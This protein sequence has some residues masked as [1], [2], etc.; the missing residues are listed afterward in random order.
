MVSLGRRYVKHRRMLGYTLSNAGSLMAFANFIDRMAPGQ[1]VTTAR[2]LEWVTAVP[3]RKLTTQVGLLSTIRGFARYCAVLDPRTQIPGRHLLGPGY[4]RLRPHIYTPQQ[5]RLILRRAR[6]LTTHLGP[7]HPMTYETLIGLIACTGMRFGEARRLNLTDFDDDGALRIARFKASP[8]RIIPLHA[9]TVRA[10]QRYV[11]TRRRCFPFSDSLFVGVTGKPLRNSRVEAIFNRLVSGLSATGDRA[12]PRMSDFRHSFASGW[13]T[14]WSRQSNPIS[15]HLLL[16]A[17][18]L[19]HQNFS[20]TWWYVS[21][22]P[23]SLRTAAN[24]FLHFHEASTSLSPA[25]R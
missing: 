2:A 18:Y 11:R 13:I 21:S 19:G 16:L 14:E 4:T 15:H 6:T 8:Q 7:L 10:L 12:R 22:D 9:T 24:T 1:P 23:R 3:S 17:R 25:D 5:T 20:S